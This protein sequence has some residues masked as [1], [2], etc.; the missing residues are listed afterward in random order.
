MSRIT[1]GAIC[2]VVFGAVSAATMIPLKFDDKPAAIT[3]AFIN[4]FAIGFVIG[5]A[6][7]NL[8]SWAQG[9]VFGLLLSLPDAII[10]KAFVPIVLMGV[11]GGTIIGFV[12]GKWGL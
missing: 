11:V 1:L 8:P 3:G 10:T 7:L 6:H 5:A 4:R 2:G 12:V 9:L